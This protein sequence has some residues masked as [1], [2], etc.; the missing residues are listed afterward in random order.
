MVFGPP[1]RHRKSI[2]IKASWW[3]LIVMQEP[4]FIQG[5]ISFEAPLARLTMFITGSLGTL[6]GKRIKSGIKANVL[7]R[8]L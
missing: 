7:F 3:L 8:L 1:G 2:S 4:S 5:L 6:K